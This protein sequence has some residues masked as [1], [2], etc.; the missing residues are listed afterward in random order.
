MKLSRQSKRKL[1]ANKPILLVL[2]SIQNRKSK[3]ANPCGGL[4]L[5]KEKAIILTKII[6][7]I[8]DKNLEI[9]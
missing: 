1:L 5:L 4:R 8:C 9:L 6:I 2:K 7:K 3:I